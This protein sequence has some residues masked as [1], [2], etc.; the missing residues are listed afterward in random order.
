MKA[1]L[2]ILAAGFLVL[3]LWRPSPAAA[4]TQTYPC[5]TVM[6]F[7]TGVST[8]TGAKFR[9]GS[10]SPPFVGLGAI[11]PN[12]GDV[13]VL[14]DPPPAWLVNSASADS[15]WIG[16]SA[17][18][19][20]DVS[21]VYIYYLPIVAPCAG[22]RIT[23]RYAASENGA[24]RLNGA[25][26]AFPTPVNG[27]T[28]WT[29]FSFNNLLAGL[30]RLEFVVTNNVGGR[31]DVTGLRAELTVTA[32]CC[33]CIELTC[34]TDIFLTTCA[35]GATANFSITGT[36]RCYT[37]LTIN[38]VLAAAET[39]PVTPST[40]F[41]IGTNAVRCTGADTVGHR[42]SCSFRVVVNRDTQPPEIRCPQDIVY[43]CQG[44]GTNVFYSPTATDGAGADPIVTCVPPSGSFFPPG[45]NQVTC[46]ARD[47]CGQIGRCSFRVLILPNG[48]TKTLQAGVADNFSPAGLEPTTPGPCV[49]GGGFFTGMPFDTAVPSR[50]LS[51]SFG[52]LP[53]SV[54]AA[55]LILHMKPLGT[56]SQ[57]DVLRIGLQTCS[58]PGVWAFTQ[59]VATLPAAGG[60]WAANAPTTFALDLAAL[61][62]GVNLLALI[63][64]SQRL[65][66]AV[67]TDTLVD[68]AR[69]E[70]T[71]CG[72]QGTLSGVPYSL[73]NVR[74]VHQ[75]NGISWQT[76]NSNGPPPTIA[77]DIGGADGYR[78]NYPSVLDGLRVC[79]TLEPLTVVCSKPGGLTVTARIL[80][81][82]VPGQPFESV[83][84]EQPGNPIGKKIEVWNGD[85]LVTHHFFA[86]SGSTEADV[87]GDACVVSQG[88]AKDHYFVNFASPQLIVLPFASAA[89]QVS[90]AVGPQFT[91]TSVRLYFRP[92]VTLYGFE[93][94]AKPVITLGSN[95]SPLSVGDVSLLHHD[96]WI[97]GFGLQ[98][99]T[100][101][102]TIYSQAIIGAQRKPY[103]DC[104]RLSIPGPIGWSLEL[105][106]VA[107]FCEFPDFGAPSCNNGYVDV[108]L[109][110]QFPPLPVNTTARMANL[111]ITPT[112]LPFDDCHIQYTA[113]SALTGEE[114]SYSLTINREVGG[115]IGL[116]NISEANFSKWPLSVE[117]SLGAEY[118][119]VV[120]P[121]HTVITVGGQNYT[122]NG[123]SFN[124]SGT[125]IGLDFAN[126]CL[127]TTL[128]QKMSF[129]SFSSTGSNLPPACVTLA[130]P[131]N[132]IVNATNEAG[133]FATFNPSGATRCGSNVVVTC[134]PP[135]GAFFPPGLTVVHCSAVDSQGS[136]DECRFLVTVNP[137]LQLR[138]TAVRPDLLELRWTGDGIVEFT[139]GLIGPAAWR[140][141]T[142]PTESNGVERLIRVVPSGDRRFFRLRQP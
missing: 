38:C 32:T 87:P 41:P 124:A 128:Q 130:C 104:V 95:S 39:F 127:E 19:A 29:T 25:P 67:G 94:A 139:E 66:F 131:T 12:A 7:G 73:N 107:D 98:Q 68:Y 79:K 118:F 30:N 65:E 48:F 45:T 129:K 33:P 74:A 57:D 24:V 110:P 132:V 121:A 91:G 115:P 23:G 17:S 8:N 76:I 64:T 112:A 122:A 85:Q 34:P 86:G 9:P 142:S 100:I 4:Q 26:T 52:G 109:Y 102:D 43:L 106:G 137:A 103:G 5:E 134:E 136:Q 18:T 108:G 72:P 99:L 75:G 119:N 28:A 88:F 138:A 55:K 60:T 62:G 56:A 37:N 27:S 40:I 101:S 97:D 133:A 96:T 47:A 93:S 92:P 21:G 70:V 77:L 35:T 63:N 126:V 20:G 49:L 105:N 53:S 6:Q 36:N 120:L 80:D 59:T 50:H 10:V 78:F 46:E 15:Q 82:P 125:F 89:T 135:S 1:I 11:F 117:G 31:G 113:E 90:G 69:L 84:L 114:V 13:F 14:T 54:T 83:L 141:I 42:A 44:G 71:Y 16:P 111:R 81:I 22:A 140:A 3:G 116:R 51:H 123:V 61:P 2:R 58:P